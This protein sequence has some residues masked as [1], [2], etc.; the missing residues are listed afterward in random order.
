MH[1]SERKAKE[2]ECSRYSGQMRL[3]S[4]MRLVGMRKM[5]DELESSACSE[6]DASVRG[7]G[8]KLMSL[9][10]PTCVKR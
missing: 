9:T 5:S 3:P 6:I 7:V 8:P 1:A 2:I 4:A 10:G